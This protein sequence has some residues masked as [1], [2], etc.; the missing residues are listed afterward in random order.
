[1]FWTP[2][3]KNLRHLWKIILTYVAYESNVS[4]LADYLNYLPYF[5][6]LFTITLF[7]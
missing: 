1:M 4:A 3:N 6:G 2:I 7:I 5:V